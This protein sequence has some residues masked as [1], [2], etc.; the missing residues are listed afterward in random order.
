VTI[1]LQAGFQYIGLYQK[2]LSVPKYPDAL[3]NTLLK[4]GANQLQ[5]DTAVALLAPYRFDTNCNRSGQG[6]MNQMAGDIEHMLWYDSASIDETSS[7]RSGV[8]L[9][10]RPC[11]MKGVKDRIWPHRAML[12]LLSQAESHGDMRS[13]AERGNEVNYPMQ[14][15]PSKTQ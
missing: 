1:T 10:K 3:M 8:W 5:L 7:Y 9:A 6:T 13:H 11:T 4:L 15:R 2:S 12:K 14:K